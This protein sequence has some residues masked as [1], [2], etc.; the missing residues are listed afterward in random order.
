MN[1]N[2]KHR[3]LHVDDSDANRYALQRILEKQNYT[4]TSAASGE[5]GLTKALSEL[6]ELIILDIKLPDINGYEVCKRLKA[7][8]V[9]AHIPILQT[10][11]SFISSEDK[12]TGLESGADGYLAQP[13]DASVL[14]AT[15]RSLF[16]ITEAE[17]KAK[18]A[19]RSQEEVLA[20]VSHDLRNPLSFIMLQTK[21]IE[22]EID[23][24][25]ISPEETIKRMRVISNT[26]L[27]MNRLIQDLLDVTT[28]EKDKLKLELSSF[29]IHSLIQDVFVYYQEPALQSEISLDRDLDDSGDLKIMADRERLLQVLGNLISNSIKF[30][31]PGGKILI[32]V[33]KKE[34]FVQFEVQDTGA[35]IPEDQLKNAFN[36][37]WK[38]HDERKSGYGIGLSIV[39]GITEAHGGKVKIESVSGTGTSVKFTIP[40]SK[41]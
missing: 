10:S 35:G 13:I 24:K 30:T 11:A 23:R 34:E 2:Y 31:P 33:S 37:Y 5:E 32:K 3:I 38:G 6:P 4:V 12:V 39:K 22:K 15:V 14:V 27:K 20:V 25:S 1:Q 17:K 41:T 18:D 21:I 7:N 40:I 16:R 28:L 8:P 9:T 26:C 36:R 19:S 29:S